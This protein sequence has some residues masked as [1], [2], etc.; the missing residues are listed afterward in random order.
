MKE[1]K[2]IAMNEEELFSILK[3]NGIEVYEIEYEMG[4]V[5][6]LDDNSENINDEAEV[7]LRK[8]FKADKLY[9]FCSDTDQTFPDE[10]MVMLGFNPYE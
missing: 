9:M 6:V 1:Y 2:V 5:C 4:N 8:H 7:V 10:I 3:E